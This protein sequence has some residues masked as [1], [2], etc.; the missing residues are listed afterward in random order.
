MQCCYLECGRIVMWWDFIG[1][2]H[3]EIVQSRTKWQADV[4]G[5]TNASGRFGTVS[6]YDGRPLP[7]PETPNM[8]LKPRE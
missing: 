6:G 7:A 4:V 3:D 5:G 1:R 2:S 8:R